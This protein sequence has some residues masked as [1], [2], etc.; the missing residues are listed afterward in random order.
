MGGMVYM[1]SYHLLLPVIGNLQFDRKKICKEIYMKNSSNTA[2]TLLV[3][4]YTMQYE[5][6]MNFKKTPCPTCNKYR[7]RF[8][9]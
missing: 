1:E 9:R 2:K 5:S 4:I 8:Q 6:S 3:M 7:D